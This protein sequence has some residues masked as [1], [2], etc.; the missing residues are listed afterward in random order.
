MK[1]HFFQNHDITHGHQKKI[2]GHDEKNEVEKRTFI[3]YYLVVQGPIKS[4]LFGGTDF[5]HTT[6]TRKHVVKCAY[7]FRF[8]FLVQP[9]K[10]NIWLVSKTEYAR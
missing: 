8:F 3:T 1:V 9:N 2:S 4:F 10:Y 6:L 5:F 7:L